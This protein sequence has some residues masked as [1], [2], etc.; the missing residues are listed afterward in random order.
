METKL[1]SHYNIEC[2]RIKTTVRIIY[3]RAIAAK[4]RT[5]VNFCKK[6]K[7]ETLFIAAT[8]CIEQ[9]KS[10]YALYQSVSKSHWRTFL[11]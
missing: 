1:P 2:L 11:P 4:A 9:E 3:T 6:K 10:V 7:T 5:K 8:L